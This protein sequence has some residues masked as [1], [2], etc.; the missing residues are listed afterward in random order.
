DG[1][2]QGHGDV[3]GVATELSAHHGDHLI[4]DDK[5]GDVIADCLYDAGRLHAEHPV[6]GPEHT[7]PGRRE[8]PQTAWDVPA[9][10]PMVGHADG[11]GVNSDEDF[12][13]AGIRSIEL[14]D[15]ND[16]WSAESVID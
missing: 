1:A 8:H 5:P 9:A 7:Q 4:A 15:P 6:S 2:V 11:A 3:L 12:V 13:A 14:L 16:L 10:G